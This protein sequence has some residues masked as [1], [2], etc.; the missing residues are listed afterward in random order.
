MTESENLLNEVQHVRD[1]RIVIGST[2][3]GHEQWRIVTAENDNGPD[4]ETFLWKTT[5]NHATV[6][7]VYKR[8]SAWEVVG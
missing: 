8:G 3:Q 2:Q 7:V 4:N 6:V 5:C 1:R